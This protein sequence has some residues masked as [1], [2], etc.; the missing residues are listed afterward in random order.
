ML[1]RSAQSGK[2]MTIATMAM[3]VEPTV[4]A[5]LVSDGDREIATARIGLRA[6]P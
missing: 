5:K 3:S 1:F 4:H 2:V 6:R